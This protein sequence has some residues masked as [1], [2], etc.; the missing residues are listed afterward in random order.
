MM[1]FASPGMSPNPANRGFESGDFSNWTV[2]IPTGHSEFGGDQPAGT[3]NVVASA[4]PYTGSAAI[5]PHAGDYFSSI[6][7]ADFGFFQASRSYDITA[8]QVVSLHAGDT[9]TG[10]A[11][12]YNG[13]FE[14]QDTASVK[15]LDAD[16]AVMSMPWCEVSGG[17]GYRSATDSTLWQWEVPDDGDYSIVL[18]MTTMGDDVAASYGFFDD[19]EVV[20]V[21]ELGSEVFLGMGLLGLILPVRKGFRLRSG[22][23]G[24]SR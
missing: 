16:N 9:V 21:P 19:I 13:D 3:A 22:S 18:D 17:L 12:F 6:G 1:A 2:T 20:A 10:W 4:G 24:S 14:P 7:S 15:I 11:R 8:C 5:Y 23:S